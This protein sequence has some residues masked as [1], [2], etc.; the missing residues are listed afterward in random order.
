MCRVVLGCLDYTLFTAG[1][2]NW[3]AR[4]STVSCWIV[5]QRSRVG[6]TFR[7]LVLVWWTVKGSFTGLS[8]DPRCVRFRDPVDDLVA[9]GT[10]DVELV[11]SRVSATAGSHC[12]FP[13]AR[14]FTTEVNT[15][16]IFTAVFINTEFLFLRFR[17]LFCVFHGAP[18][19]NSSEVLKC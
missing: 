14:H 1:S 6:S 3:G 18:I 12:S 17:S 9:S 13:L 8:P 2:E 4:K 10:D 15:A 7:W 16:S 11:Y 5:I 19:L